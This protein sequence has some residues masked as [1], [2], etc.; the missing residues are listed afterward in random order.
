MHH[1]STYFTLMWRISECIHWG[2]NRAFYPAE[3]D[4]DHQNWPAHDRWLE[5]RVKKT[6]QKKQRAWWCHVKRK[7]VYEQVTFWQKITMI[8]H[9]SIH[10]STNQSTSIQ[11]SIHPSANPSTSIHQS[12][13]PTYL[14]L[15]YLSTYAYLLL[16]NYLPSHSSIHPY[17]PIYTIY[18]LIYFYSSIDPSLYSSIHPSISTHLHYIPTHLLLFVFLSISSHIYLSIHPSY[19]LFS[20]SSKHQKRKCVYFLVSMENYHWFQISDS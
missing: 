8:I 19:I 18:P 11:P 6:K 14:L 9:P 16:Y 3:N 1:F 17:L 13:Q 2:K 10:F 4:L 15:Q 7:I 12:Y 20:F 5:G